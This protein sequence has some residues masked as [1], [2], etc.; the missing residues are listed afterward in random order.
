MKNQKE[1]WMITK[2]RKG[3]QSN[4]NFKETK[5]EKVWSNDQKC[6]QATAQQQKAMSKM[7]EARQSGRKWQQR[8]KQLQY[9]KAAAERKQS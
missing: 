4:R 7:K 5:D 1:T 9:K 2:S 6:K 8:D 3:L